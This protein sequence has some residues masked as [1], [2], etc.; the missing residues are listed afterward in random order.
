M[1][2]VDIDGTISNT[3][4]SNMLFNPLGQDR[5]SRPIDGARDALH[6]IHAVYEIAYV[7]ARPRHLLS[8]TSKWLERH[9]FPRAPLVHA[10]SPIDYLRQAAYK[11]EMFAGLRRQWPHLLI[12][13]GD[14]DVD[15]SGYGRNGMLPIIVNAAASYQAQPHDIVINNWHELRRYLLDHRELMANADRLGEALEQSVR[16]PRP[17]AMQ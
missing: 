9:G 12:G 13:I 7:T 16:V 2:A 10:P 5:E 17:D 4:Y 14:R 1:I 8:K 6:A 11:R 15:S 3:N